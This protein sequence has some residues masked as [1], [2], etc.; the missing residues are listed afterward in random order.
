MSDQ[1]ERTHK[2]TPKRLADARKRGDVALAPDLVG[3]ATLAGAAIALMVGASAVLDQLMALT[4]RVGQ[5]ADG[6]PTPGLAGAGLRT[7]VACAAPILIVAS[8]AALVVMALQVGVPPTFKRPSFDLG[9]LSPA[10]NLGNALGG[11]AMGRRLAGAIA[12]L[13]GIGLIVVLLV[14]RPEALRMT[15]VADLQTVVAGLAGRALLAVTAVLAAVGVVAYVLA[16]RRHMASLRMSSDEVK[17][18]HHENE[19]N[20]MLRGRRR[21]R[22]RELAKRRIDVAVASASVVVVNPTHYAVALRYDS[23]GP[24]P[25]IVV[26]KGVDAVA[27][28]IR[29]KAR[30]AGVPI[31]SRPPLAR[32]LHAAVPEGREIPAALYQAVAE[33]LAYVYRVQRRTA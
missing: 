28:R 6:A 14:W 22:M 21:A 15:S 2:P 32:A 10:K 24:R 1:A 5:G 31:L 25:P 16:R 3:A 23:G 18:E 8:I 12:K 20:P 17:R 7:F 13:G 29:E 9:R 26:A 33:V 19:G 30:Q 27:A 11:K 4:Q